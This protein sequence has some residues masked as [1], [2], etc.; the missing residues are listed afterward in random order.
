MHMHM[1]PL[2]NRSARYSDT[3]P[4]FDNLFSPVYLTKC[5]LMIDGNILFYD[6]AML[7]TPLIGIAAYL[8]LL[9]GFY[10]NDNIVPFIHPYS[11]FHFNLLAIAI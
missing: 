1:H 3:F 9:K 7:L 2:C 6:K 10:Q 5:C 8:I 4:V 11:T